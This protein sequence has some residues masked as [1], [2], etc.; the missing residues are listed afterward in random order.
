MTYDPNAYSFIPTLNEVEFYKTD[1]SDPERK[2]YY[3]QFGWEKLVVPAAC[4]TVSGKMTALKTLFV[5][6]YGFRRLNSETMERWQIRLQNRFDQFVEEM[7]RAYTLYSSNLAVMNSDIVKGQKVVTSGSDGVTSTSKEIDTPDSAVN[8]DDDYADRLNKGSATTTY[9]KTSTVTI[10]GQVVDDVNRS[11]DSWRDLDV[12]FISQ[13]E[14]NFLNVF[15]NDDVY[16]E[17]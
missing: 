6:R 4:T 13:F 16:S 14:N 12:F 1:T 17:V 3:S 5:G 2:A 10:T 9:G 11:I 7:E 15:D 8:D